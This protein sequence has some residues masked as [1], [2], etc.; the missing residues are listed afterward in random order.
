ME[1]TTHRIIMEFTKC[2][3]QKHR[4]KRIRDTFIRDWVIDRLYRFPNGLRVQK[5]KKQF[6]DNA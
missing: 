1:R 3:A 2:Y 6:Y 5:L 4:S